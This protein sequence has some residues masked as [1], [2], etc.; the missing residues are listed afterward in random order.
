MGC[1]AA[2]FPPDCGLCCHRHCKDQVRVACKKRPETKGEPGPPGAPVP[3]APSPASCGKTQNTVPAQE[4]GPEDGLT[5]LPPLTSQT[6]SEENLSYT[7]SL[8]TES[9]CHLRH[10]WTQTESS[11]SS[12]E[13]GM[14]RSPELHP[15][16][17]GYLS[18]INQTDLGITERQN[19]IKNPLSPGWE[20]RDTKEKK[21]RIFFFE[22]V[23]HYV[24]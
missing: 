4:E 21:E 6:G 23:S 5:S 7:L 10:A 13:A 19:H 1:S 11:H 8:D 16:E 17:E 2:P 20:V 18:G 9:G 15:G 22:M 14:V 3:A 12:Q 24:S